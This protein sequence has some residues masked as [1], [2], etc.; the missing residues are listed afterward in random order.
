MPFGLS[1]VAV[2]AIGIGLL[3]LALIAGYA[4]FVEHEKELGAADELAKS[5]AAAMQLAQDNAAK[6]AKIAADQQGIAHDAQLQANAARADAASAV[7][8]GSALRVQLNAYVSS[9]RGPVYSPA[10]IGGETTDDPIGMLATLLGRVDD[11]AGR[12]AAEA[13]ANWIGWSA[14]TKSYD[15]LTAAKP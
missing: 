11:A 12:Y 14:C 10:A 4:L 8:A 15:A 13:D 5:S 7:A 6:A 3:V 2:K 1:T 9:R